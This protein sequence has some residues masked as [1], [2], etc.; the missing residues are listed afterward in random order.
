MKL[1][2]FLGGFIIP[3]MMTF[4]AC[5]KVENPPFSQADMWDCH[6]EL[7]WD[8]LQTQNSLIGIWE[9]EYIGC[10]WNPENA[11]NESFKGMTIEFKSDSTLIVKEYEQI[12]QTSK[13][14]VVKGDGDLFAIDVDPTVIQ[15]YGRILF[16]DQIVE[17]NH[18]YIDGCDNYFKR[19]D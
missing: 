5:N 12:T 10:Y 15:L 13:W 14:V 19:I 3:T 8:S 1:I 16:C 17:F 9:W 6:N 2:H 18:S 11:N 7:K 4:I